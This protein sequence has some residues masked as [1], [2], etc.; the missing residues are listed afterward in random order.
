MQVKNHR[1]RKTVLPYFKV[2]LLWCP[3]LKRSNRLLVSQ[4]SDVDLKFCEM[5]VLRKSGDNGKI[6]TFP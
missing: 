4:V 1:N 2:T 6:F 5:T 3:V